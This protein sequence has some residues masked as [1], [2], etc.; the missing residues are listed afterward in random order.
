MSDG[1]SDRPPEEQTAGWPVVS[2]V[3]PG[4]PP[5]RG[6]SHATAATGRVVCLAG[7]IGWDPTTGQFASDDFAEQTRQA[8][9][10]I[11]TVLR[12]AGAEPRHLTRLT[13]YITDKEAYVRARP[14]IGAAYR[15]LIGDHYPAMSVVVAA[16]LLE[17]RALVE[18]EA[19]AVVPADRKGS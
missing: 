16:G 19:T 7:Q 13:W 2:R 6:Y 14:A 11:V 1:S 9:A 3:P 5:P 17:D 10:N 8:L 12:T 15:A 4:W 18:I